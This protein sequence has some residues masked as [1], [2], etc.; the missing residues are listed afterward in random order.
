MLAD[1]SENQFF[2]IGQSRLDKMF[3]SELN[4]TKIQNIILKPKQDWYG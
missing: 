2:S 1:S 4:L 3:N